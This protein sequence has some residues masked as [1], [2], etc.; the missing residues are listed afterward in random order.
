MGSV[1]GYFWVYVLRLECVMQYYNA[2]LLF[3]DCLLNYGCLLNYLMNVLI[4]PYY[5]YLLNY[6]HGVGWFVELCT[7][8]YYW[9]CIVYETWFYRWS[10]VLR[11]VMC[12]IYRSNTG[13][14]LYGMEMTLVCWIHAGAILSSIDPMDSLLS[15]LRGYIVYYYERD[16]TEYIA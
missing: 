5:G 9:L 7:Y 12:Y 16:S 10:L 2:F 8:M 4:T 6:I 3:N 1:S 13:L 14:R 15:C 11:T